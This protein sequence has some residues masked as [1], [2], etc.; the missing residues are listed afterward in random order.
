MTYEDTTE[1]H[2]KFRKELAKLALVNIEKKFVDKW[3]TVYDEIEINALKHIQKLY[4]NYQENQTIEINFF[5]QEELN[6]EISSTVWI[7]KVYYDNIFRLFYLYFEGFE[8]SID[9]RGIPESVGDPTYLEYQGQFPEH[10]IRK[11]N[12]IKRKIVQLHINNRNRV[13]QQFNETSTVELNEVNDTEDEIIQERRQERR[14]R[15]PKKPAR[16]RISNEKFKEI[17]NENTR[18]ELVKK[19]DLFTLKILRAQS[20]TLEKAHEKLE[21][22]HKNK[23]EYEQAKIAKL[24]SESHK[25]YKTLIDKE[26][27]ERT[28]ENQN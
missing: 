11:V 5:D 15:K 17:L 6:I 16:K 25:H 18:K 1:K 21:I 26:I 9:E 28:K 4:D 3:N 19:S 2:N 8:N 13:E 22:V 14:E 27:K 7:F 24:R 20:E 23:E 12:E 10:S